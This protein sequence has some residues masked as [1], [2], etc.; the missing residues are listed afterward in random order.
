MHLA[1]ARESLEEH[2]MRLTGDEGV[3]VECPRGGVVTEFLKSRRSRV[4]WG[5]AIGFSIAPFVMGLSMVILKD[6]RRPG[7]WACSGPRHS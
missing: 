7:L 1:I 4:P 2:F 5:V 6:P 3:P